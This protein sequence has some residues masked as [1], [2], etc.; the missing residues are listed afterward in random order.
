M[1]SICQIFSIYTASIYKAFVKALTLIPVYESKNTK[2]PKK[3]ICIFAIIQQ[4][5]ITFLQRQ[6]QLIIFLRNQKYMLHYGGI[7]FYCT[8]EILSKRK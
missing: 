7:Y 8:L 1:Y 3:F 4:M 6:N 5:S 2:K